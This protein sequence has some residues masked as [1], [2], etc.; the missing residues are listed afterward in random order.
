[1]G[2]VTE[3]LNAHWFVKQTGREVTNRGQHVVSK[4]HPFMRANLDGITKTAKGH[5]SYIDFKHVGRF[6]DSVIRRYTPQMTHCCTILGFDYWTLSVFIG[7]SKWE[8]VDGEVDPFYREE[9]LAREIAF[10]D[11]VV[12]DIDPGDR[13]EEKPAVPAPQPRLREIVVP[14]D[15]TSVGFERLCRDNNWLPEVVESLVPTFAS[16]LGAANLHALTRDKIKSAVPEDIGR[17]TYGL[18]TY[19]RDKRGI[20]LSLAKGEE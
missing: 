12:Y 20:S 1:M 18:F 7:S 3:E 16:T 17:L 11:C 4:R 2:S 14:T 5:D 19:K 10:W 13:F 15:N 8:T 9:L 6:D